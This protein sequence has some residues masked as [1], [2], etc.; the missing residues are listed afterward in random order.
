MIVWLRGPQNVN[1]SFDFS[2]ALREYID[3]QVISFNEGLVC[4]LVYGNL[5]FI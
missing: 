5:H 1:N 2:D 3:F 4:V